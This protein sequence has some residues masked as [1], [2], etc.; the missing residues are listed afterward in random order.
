MWN[1][2]GGELF[3][4]ANGKIIAARVQTS[5]DFAVARRDSLFDDVYWS[6]SAGNAYADYDVSPDGKSFAF[7]K[8]NETVQ[9]IIVTGWTQ[10]VLQQLSRTRA[11]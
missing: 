10:T 6:T 1:P 5:P 7:V 11:K 8:R 4:R 2:R 3:Y 9:P